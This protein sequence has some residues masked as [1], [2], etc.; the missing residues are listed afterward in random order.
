ME[1]PPADDRQQLW[2]RSSGNTGERPYISQYA[3]ATKRSAERHP[4]QSPRWHPEPMADWEDMSRWA[5]HFTAPDRERPSTAPLPEGVWASAHEREARL[6]RQDTTGY[7]NSISILWDR[8]VRPFAEPH[9]AGKDVSAVAE[10]HRSAAVS[11]IPLHLLDR[12]VK[13]RSSYGIGFSQDYLVKQGGA[14]VWY[15]EEGGVLA[16]S[17]RKQVQD[18]VE[19]EID[20][21]DPFWTLTPFVEFSDPTQSFGDWRWE[22]EWRVPGGLRFEPTDVAFLFLPEQFHDAARRFFADHQAANTGPA[23][24][25]PYIDVTWDRKRITTALEAA[26]KLPEPSSSA[27]YGP[28]EGLHD[29]Y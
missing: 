3:P 15:L 5:V 7:Q 22:R 11:E 16:A 19:A 9:G 14:R 27:S 24:L 8:F 29:Y 13:A 23:Y 26:P 25:C 21:Q 1:A 12:L 28:M 18:R 4:R 6:R 10:G 20:P 17:V 2:Q